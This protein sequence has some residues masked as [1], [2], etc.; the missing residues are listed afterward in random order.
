MY[1]N[2]NRDINQWNRIESSEINPSIYGQ[3]TYDKG[4]QNIQSKKIVSPI[5]GAGKTGKLDVKE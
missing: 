4:G 3:L 5:N 1:W 2:K